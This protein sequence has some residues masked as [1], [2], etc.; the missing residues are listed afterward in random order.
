MSTVLGA[1]ISQKLTYASKWPFENFS[2]FFPLSTC[3]PP[4]LAVECCL[5]GFYMQ[6]Q[7]NMCSLC[8]CLN[9]TFWKSGRR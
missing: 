9:K 3:E 7:Y 5:L 6:Q 8:V 4:A 1:L 2:P